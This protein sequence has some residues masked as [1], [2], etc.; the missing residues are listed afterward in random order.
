MAALPSD[1]Y[2]EVPLYVHVS[3]W[4]LVTTHA[5]L[6]ELEMYVPAP[7]IQGSG[8]VYFSCECG[9]VE[10]YHLLHKIGGQL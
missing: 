1:H 9:E 7:T 4:P 6:M 5:Q 10:F 2:T 8:D 3:D